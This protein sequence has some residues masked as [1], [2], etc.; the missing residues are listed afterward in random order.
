MRVLRPEIGGCESVDVGGSIDS[1]GAV[2]E[3]GLDRVVFV[4]AC[5]LDDT[6][7]GDLL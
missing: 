6:V 2:F 4:L 1:V 7:D 5:D 3:V